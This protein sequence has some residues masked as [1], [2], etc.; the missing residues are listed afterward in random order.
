MILG[1]GAYMSPEQAR[2]QAVDKRTDVWAFGCVLYEMLTGR[3][4]FSGDTISDTIAAILN[5][6]PDWTALPPTLPPAVHR[7]VRRC[8]QK[9]QRRRVHDIADARVEIDETLNPVSAPVASPTDAAGAKRR[10]LAI[11]VGTLVLA[12]VTLSLIAWRVGSRADPSVTP[13]LTYL[14]LP[15]PDG[16]GLQSP[17]TVSPDGSSIAFVGN[18]GKGRQLFVRRLVLQNSAPSREQ[19]SP[20]THSGRLMGSGSRSLPA[21]N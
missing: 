20:A 6:E 21:A 9:D 1:T 19:N 18:D 2:G 8:L 13:A 15:L 11:V 4:A 5:R 10:M 12:G 7:L 17:P 3:R 16:V 14:T